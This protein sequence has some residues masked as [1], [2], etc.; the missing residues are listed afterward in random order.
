MSAT[1]KASVIPY[2]VCRA[3]FGSTRPT[4]RS[5]RAGTGAPADI[6]SRTPSRAACC[7]WPSA[8]AVATTFR[9]AAGEAKTTVASTAAAASASAAAVSVPGAVTVMS[10]TTA[11]TPRAGP[12][13]AK[14]AKA[15][16]SRS[17][18]VSR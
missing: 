15:A 1:G 17:A 14:G 8:P 5:S 9:S 12:Y 3:A 10:G 7:A 18:S 2:G 16:T 6:T 4:W 13:S 11:P